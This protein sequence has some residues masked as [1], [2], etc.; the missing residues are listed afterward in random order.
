MG[1]VV[2]A[3]EY[4]QI[5]SVAVAERSSGIE[6][7]VSNSNPLYNMMKRKGKMRAF[8]GPEV[9][10]TL[11]ID[12]QQA[13]WA[14]AYDFLA[15]PPIE[16]FND[17]VFSPSAIYVPI[18]LTGQEIRANQGRSQVHD[19]I[20]ST[21]EAAEMALVDAFEVALQGDGT[22]DGGKAIIGMAG[23]LPIITNSG[24]YGGIDRATVPLWRTTTFDVQSAFPLI[25]TQVNA[26]TIRPLMARIMAQR[27]RANRS[28]DLFVMSEEHYFA[29]D[30][31]TIAIQRIQREG[32][33]G[34]LGF[35]SIE[36]VGGGTRAEIVLASGLNNAMPPNTTYGIDCSS[37]SLRY[38]EGFNFAKLFDG[39]GQM[40]INQDAIAQFVGWEGAMTMSNPLFNWRF[41]DSNPGA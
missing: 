28:A 35:K 14:R 19:V 13:Q 21:L 8:S 36:Y 30:A 29:Y 17:A 20:D 9:R 26:T 4:R 6:D 25:G 23:A 11:Q 10:Q 2:T 37:L 41:Y 39:D 34:Q 40:P 38:R 32:S 7:L 24:V 18:S 27:S 1:S 33:L 31:A 16:L 5:L 22:A 12:K 15:N 3:R